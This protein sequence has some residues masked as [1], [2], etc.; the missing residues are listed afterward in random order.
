MDRR[1]FV[2]G[3]AAASGLLLLKPRTVFGYEANSA[4]R[5]GLLGC[6]SR[7]TTVATSFAND[8]KTRVVALAD[9]FPDKLEAGK[10]HFD[11]LADSL[12]YPKVDPKMMFR[13]YRAFEEIASSPDV[14]AVQ[15]S[16]PPWF[17]VQHLDAAVKGGKHVYCEKPIG[18]DV[19]QSKQALEIGKRAQG[20]VSLEVGFQIRSAPPFVEIVRRIQ[21]GDLGKI[22]V[23]SANYNAPGVTYPPMPGMSADEL[24]IRR[25]YWDL[26]LSGDIIVEQAIH[27]V[28][29]CN[30]ALQEHPLKATGTGGRNIISHPGNTWDN[31]EVAFTYPENVHV[32]FS[33]TQ[34]GPNDWFDVSARLFG[35]D[36]LAQAP[37]SGPL[38]I[39][40][41]HP[42]TW[43]SQEPAKPSAPT[44]FAA[45]GVFSDNLA[46]A[47]REKDRSFIDSITSGN[48]HNQINA[49]VET[50]FSAMLGRMAG[51]LG[52]E[53]TWEELLQHGE[54][55]EL[56][57]NMSQF[58]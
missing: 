7:G 46:Q 20:H 57:I 24:R 31:Y 39:I 14:D 56:D 15:I 44:T 30:W 8:T 3:A 48:F 2:G 38:R 37:Y 6:G 55:Y 33:C 22:G 16:T 45:N 4:V 12:N 19:A 27:L 9:L 10:A 53:V 5:L 28:D 40:G 43:A 54:N 34:F 41:N 23:I 1:Q 25:W 58:S 13:G 32:S 17:H 29:I 51:R 18:V 35:A 36:G 49:G 11:Q 47:Q 50:A 26:T 42:W 52:R 21:A